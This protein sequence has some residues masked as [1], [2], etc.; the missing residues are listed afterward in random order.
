MKNLFD[1]ATKE[2]SQDAFLRWFFENY[3]DEQIGPIVVDFI[4]A[5]T[6]GQ[7]NNRNQF[8]LKFGDI[9]KLVSYSQVNDIDISIDFWCEKLFDGHRTIVIEDKTDSE[10]HNQLVKYNSAISN[11]KYGN[12]SP[13]ECVYKI[14][15]KTHLIEEKE[16]KRVEDAG[17]TPF[18]IDEI[19]NFFNRYL[20]KTTSDVLN[21]Y[22]EHIIGIHSC[23]K[24]VSKEKANTWN[25]INWETFFHKFMESHKEI[26]HN[27]TSYRGIYSS[28][29][30]Y[31]NI[32]N[33]KYLTYV[34]FE[35]QIRS[36]LIPYLHPGFHVGDKQEWSIGAFENEPYYEECKK[37]L[38]E[39][40][41]FVEKCNSSIIKR[42][43]S[44]RSFGKIEETIK[45][46]KEADELMVELDKWVIEFKRII[47]LYNEDNK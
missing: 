6:Q 27:F 18:G 12:K 40:R 39:L 10:E 47:D 5:F 33:G 37:E 46:D 32:K 44:A 36:S 29:L 25:S 30:L 41:S 13:D 11:W 20:N 34:A 19:Y 15:Y 8:N 14:F 22:I 2:L 35:I 42:G 28:M 23:Y 26:E 9:T 43:N 16:H 17:W 4:N 45:T 7:S 3:E 24:T 21:D 31:L 38:I 1:Y